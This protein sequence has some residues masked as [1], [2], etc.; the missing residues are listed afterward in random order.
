[1][2]IPDPLLTVFP[3]LAL[4]NYSQLLP[5]TAGIASPELDLLLGLEA[6]IG[7]ADKALGLY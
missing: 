3:V 6:Q 4:R 1:L 2:L 5:R 7:T